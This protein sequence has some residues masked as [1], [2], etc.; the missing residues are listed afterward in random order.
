MAGHPR[1]V[2]HFDMVMS[3]KKVPYIVY[4]Y[5]MSEA[6]WHRYLYVPETAHG[7]YDKTLK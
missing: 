7:R 6:S 3:Q 5:P 2:Q 1:D 4:S